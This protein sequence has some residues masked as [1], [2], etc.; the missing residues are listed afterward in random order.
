MRR[1]ISRSIGN[2]VARSRR[3]VHSSAIAVAVAGIS[4]LSSISVAQVAGA[5][6]GTTVGSAVSSTGAATLNKVSVLSPVLFHGFD[7]APLIE[8][9]KTDVM[10]VTKPFKLYSWSKNGAAPYWDK[11]KSGRDLFLIA[12][13]KAAAQIFWKNIGHPDG[14]ENMYGFGLYL[15][16]DPVAT[17]GYGQSY[18]D[19]T[20]KAKSW[21]LMELTVPV[22][23]LFLD[24]NQA[25]RFSN[26]VGS[27]MTNFSCN[28]NS[29]EELFRNGAVNQAH[30]CI[31]LIKEVYIKHLHI[32]AFSYEYATSTFL[33][34]EK[35]LQNRFNDRSRALVITDADW[36][37]S[38]NTLLLNSTSR[39]ETEERRLIETLFTSNFDAY[40]MQEQLNPKAAHDVIIDLLAKLPTYS[41]SDGGTKCSGTYCTMTVDACPP[42]VTPNLDPELQCESRSI[43]LPVPPRTIFDAQLV[44]NYGLHWAEFDGKPKSSPK[45]VD[46]W[47]NSNRLGCS[48]ET[49]YLPLAPPVAP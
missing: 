6:A 24:L 23:F 43:G 10:R 19:A 35:G 47:L 5:T 1:T 46:A 33:T 34:C 31:S 15:S 20:L 3:H 7:I 16:L 18:L 11:M 13:A 4:A 30:S 32:N 48:G 17:R 26:D 49:Q 42:G 25:H 21:Q 22:G 41:I 28:A 9:A 45:E 27:I 40:H 29:A 38:S 39:D 36:I 8:F 12:G 37:N 44:S 2:I 14:N